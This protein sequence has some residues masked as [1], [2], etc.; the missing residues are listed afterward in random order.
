M[1]DTAKSSSGLHIHAAPFVPGSCSKAD[2]K[3]NNGPAASK[4]G[5]TANGNATQAKGPVG[6][7]A[8]Q[9]SAPDKPAEERTAAAAAPA[10]SS[11]GSGGGA[12]GSKGGGKQGGSGGGASK[13]AAAASAAP[14]VPSTTKPGELLLPSILFCAHPCIY[15]CCVTASAFASCKDFMAAH[16]S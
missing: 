5:S 8:A 15:A 1:A 6:N 7:A 13:L 11:K 9:V 12:K 2:L 3:S 14:F 16:C 10:G 4:P